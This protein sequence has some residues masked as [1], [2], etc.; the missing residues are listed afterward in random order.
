MRL[1]VRLTQ[2]PV[3]YT[4]L[5]A[6]NIYGTRSGEYYDTIPTMG[7]CDSAVTVNLTIIS[8][9]TSVTQNLGVLTAIPPKQ[10]TNGSIAIITMPPLKERINKSSHQVKM[11]IML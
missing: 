6:A 3:I 5:P 10:P 9:D 1:R 7:D 2:K 8:V 4:L 11:A